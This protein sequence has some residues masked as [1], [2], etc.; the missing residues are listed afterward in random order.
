MMILTCKYKFVSYGWVS[1]S[2][3]FSLLVLNDICVIA[4]R[5]PE[6][7]CYRVVRGAGCCVFLAIGAA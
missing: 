7:F 5:Y 3:L 1:P 6:R 4:G 2:T